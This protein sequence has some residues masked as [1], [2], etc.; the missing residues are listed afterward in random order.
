MLSSAQ[1]ALWRAWLIM[2]PHSSTACAA[3]RQVACPHSRA[4]CTGVATTASINSLA[5]SHTTY[6]FKLHCHHMHR[7]HPTCPSP[8]CTTM[9]SCTALPW[10]L[11]MHAGHY[12]KPGHVVHA[13]ARTHED[14][15]VQSPGSPC[16]QSAALMCPL[17]SD[18]H[19]G[20]APSTAPSCHPRDASSR[21]GSW[22]TSAAPGQRSIMIT[23]ASVA[24]SAR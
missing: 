8:I 17:T 13:M 2:P 4:A 9:P 5:C 23:S 3:G 6:A 22:R 10:P 21:R 24:R 18:I 19:I 12:T 15:R 20:S 14:S 16:R 11:H 7:S 1:D